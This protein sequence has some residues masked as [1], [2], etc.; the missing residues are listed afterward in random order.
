MNAMKNL[1]FFMSDFHY[2]NAFMSC[3][4]HNDTSFFHQLI[5]F[6]TLYT[7]LHEGAITSLSHG[8]AKLCYVL[9]RFTF[10]ICNVKLYETLK[11]I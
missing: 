8:Q 5:I 9:L 1:F 3:T 4:T 7:R 11:Y 2:E 10:P 6:M